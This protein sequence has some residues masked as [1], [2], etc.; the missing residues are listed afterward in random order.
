MKF[1]SNLQHLSTP[2]WKSYNIDYN[3]L[4]YQIKIVTNNKEASTKIT[5]QQLSK[6][7]HSFIENIEYANLFVITKYG[8]LNRKLQHLETLLNKIREE[9][10]TT[11]NANTNANTN[12]S[13]NANTNANTN[14]Y[15]IEIDELFY[16]ALEISSVLKN[17]SK[18]I[19]LQKIA[20]KKLF[21][22]FLKYHHSKK[23]AVT[24]VSDL[25]TF[26]LQNPKSLINFDLSKITLELTNFI[27]V[28][29]YERNMI[30]KYSQ[31]PALQ[32][33]NSLFS[34]AS[35]MNSSSDYQNSILQKAT[36]T[37]MATESRTGTGIGT[38]TCTP[39]NIDSSNYQQIPQTPESYFDLL[40]LLKKNFKLDCLVPADITNDVTLNFN[41]YLNLKT[42]NED[43]MSTTY[44]NNDLLEEPAMIVSNASNPNSL[45]IA[46]IGGLRKYSYCI[47]PN[48]IVQIF[49]NHLYDRFNEEYK[50]QLFDYFQTATSLTKK[51]I[52]FIV[53]N[54]YTPKSK[55]F[56]KR[57]RY[58]IVDDDD[59]DDD[60]CDCES[61]NNYG[62]EN[63]NI[64][65]N[66][67]EDNE[68]RRSERKKKMAP[69]EDDGYL[70][71]F[72]RDIST[73][74]KIQFISVIDFP[75]DYHEMDIFPHNHLGVYSN[76]P[77]LADFESSLLTDVDMKTG[78]VENKFHTTNFRRFPK[79]LQQIL[80]NNGI[81]LYKGF[82][83]YQYQLSCYFNIVPNAKYINNHY[84][85]LLKLN[86]LKTFE[87]V[88]STHQQSNQEEA[89]IRHKST[90]ILNHKLSLQSRKAI[91]EEVQDQDQQ[92]QQQQQERQNSYNSSVF[93]ISPEQDS[94]SV[95]PAYIHDDNQIGAFVQ[96]VLNLKNKFF[97]NE[98]AI[99][100]KSS[101]P[102]NKKI[103][104]NPFFH[105]ASEID[106]YTRLLSVY[107]NQST[108]YD[109]INDEPV[110]YLHR[111][112]YQHKYEYNYDQ[113]LSYIYFSI[114]IVSLFLSGLQL[115]IFYS[116][117][118]ATSPDSSSRFVVRDNLGVVVVLVFA[119]IVSMLFNLIGINLLFYR[120]TQAPQMHSSIVWGGLVITCMGICWSCTLL[121]GNL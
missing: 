45:I 120:F 70:L 73:T 18:Y 22:K 13:A 95:S 84:T 121:I 49:L 36:A 82:D 105:E 75:E 81:T 83:Y 90:T 9:G 101:S 108:G 119:M 59:D 91:E 112:D 56:Y 97:N 31:T 46:P 60:D 113:T 116:I 17:L 39:S 92:Q 30:E 34:I 77:N 55:V 58:T 2:Q 26:M 88:E 76:Q 12:A 74:D 78:L 40:T 99:N 106:P 107:Q 48:N 7:Q 21:K 85:N 50:N 6:L 15:F 117:F 104:E 27:N 118:K 19:L 51:T 100:T 53:A 37:A 10:N 80:G 35:T 5:R 23:E 28:I 102:Y 94:L 61:N 79:K 16:Q 71:S 64:N 57:A 62:K 43:M 110:S 114:T 29:K 89:I 44:L 52:N 25:K 3:D 63:N 68:D 14:A 38:G 33:K 41:I 98:D 96:S 32:R 1:G 11:T 103:H 20:L 4:K 65:N 42:F 109:S 67:D 115:G 54:D 8:E 24:F 86:L 66:V 47:L 87:N 93:D 72:E 111:N 69:S